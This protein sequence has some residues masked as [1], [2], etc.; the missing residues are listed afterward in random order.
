MLNVDIASSQK[1]AVQHELR[2]MICNF[3]TQP[4]P[5]PNQLSAYLPGGGKPKRCPPVR[6][7]SV[8]SL[9]FPN[10][11]QWILLEGAPAAASS[12]AQRKVRVL[13]SKSFAE[14]KRKEKLRFHGWGEW[15]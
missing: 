1:I 8:S 2:D 7:W 3:L 12:K 6:F 9:H 15:R 13:K 11:Q 14:H 5:A 4:T 10:K